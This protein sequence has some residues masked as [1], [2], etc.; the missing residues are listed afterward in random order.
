MSVAQAARRRG[1]RRRLIPRHD[2]QRRSVDPFCT[3]AARDGGATRPSIAARPST[4]DP[5]VQPR[6]RPAGP[7]LARSRHA[8]RAFPN[9][10]ATA[11]AAKAL[12]RA[13]STTAAPRCAPAAARPPRG[14]AAYGRGS[15]TKSVLAR[16]SAPHERPQPQRGDLRESTFWTAENWPVSSPSHHGMLSAGHSDRRN[17]RRRRRGFLARGESVSAPERFVVG[18]CGLHAPYSGALGQTI[19]RLCKRAR[20]Q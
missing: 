15:M 14:Q 9:R 1:N 11:L 2:G 10:L 17:R 12:A 6:L 18:V 20:L 19:I 7:D 4:R 8:M 13:V 16:T 3:V 5:A